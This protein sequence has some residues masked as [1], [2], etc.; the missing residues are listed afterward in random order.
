MG[1]VSKV[2]NLSAILP[3]RFRSTMATAAELSNAGTLSY[4]M[5]VSYFC[6]VGMLQRVTIGR[7]AL[8]VML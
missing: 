5:L 8:P 6:A 3:F 4:S 7:A 2:S 1:T